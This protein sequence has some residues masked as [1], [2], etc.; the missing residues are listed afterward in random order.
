[1]TK[2]TH[3]NPNLP[4]ALPI[5]SALWKVRFACRNSGYHPIWYGKEGGPMIAR[6]AIEDAA[7]AYLA[8]HKN[9][10]KCID[11]I[12]PFQPNKD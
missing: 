8:E 12:E 1:M 9:W 7:K 10:L 11:V 3:E 4:S 5:G 2:T 6:S